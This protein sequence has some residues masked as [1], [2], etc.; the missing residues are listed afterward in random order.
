MIGSG[1]FNAMNLTHTGLSHTQM[2]V[3]RNVFRFG[4]ICLN[5]LDEHEMVK[6]PVLGPGECNLAVECLR[7][8]E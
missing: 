5:L 3:T 2:P 8:T 7:E 1:S 4:D 6:S